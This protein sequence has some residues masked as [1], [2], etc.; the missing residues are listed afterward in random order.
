MSGWDAYNVKYTDLADL[1]QQY[2]VYDEN[3][4]CKTLTKEDAKKHKIA[5]DGQYEECEQ[6]HIQFTDEHEIGDKKY[7]ILY[8]PSG[9]IIYKDKTPYDKPKTIQLYMYEPILSPP[10]FEPKVIKINPLFGA[11]IRAK[12]A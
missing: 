9:L 11:K 3:G 7:P 1:Q 8:N 4:F 12:N 6:Q 2:Y 10:K 5:L